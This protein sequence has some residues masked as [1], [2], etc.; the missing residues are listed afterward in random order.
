MRNMSEQPK[1]PLTRRQT[2]ILKLL[3][4]DISSNEIGKRLGISHKTVEF[5]R[6]E[7]RKRLAVKGTAGL[8]RYAI[9]EGIIKP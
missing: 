3:C 9:R 6:T 5:H 1:A 8:V 2:A 7:M 4:E